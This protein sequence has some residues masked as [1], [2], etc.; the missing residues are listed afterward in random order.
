MKEEKRKKKGVFFSIFL[1]FF[2]YCLFVFTFFFTFRHRRPCLFP[3][4]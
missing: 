1:C 3:C 2:F 4:L